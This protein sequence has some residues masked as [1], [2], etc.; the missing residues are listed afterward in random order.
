MRYFFRRLLE[1]LGLRERRKLPALKVEDIQ[2]ALE[3]ARE[4]LAKNIT[5][6]NPIVTFWKKRGYDDK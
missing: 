6:P 3:Q 5:E 1:R 2:P 4:Q